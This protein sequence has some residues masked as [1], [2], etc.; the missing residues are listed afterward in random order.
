TVFELT[1][2]NGKS[3]EKILH[4]FQVQSVDGHVVAWRR[5]PSEPASHRQIALIVALTMQACEVGETEGIVDDVGIAV[6]DR[7][8]GSEARSQQAGTCL[9]MAWHG[10]YGHCPDTL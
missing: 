10:R 9:A 4:S 2:S 7:Y 3:S 1:R 6:P 5:H 8:P